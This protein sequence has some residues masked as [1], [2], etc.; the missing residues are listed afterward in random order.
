M[1]LSDI[2]LIVIIA[3]LGVGFWEAS[4]DLGE[5]T[6]LLDQ[7]IDQPLTFGGGLAIF[8]ISL[9]TWTPGIPVDTLPSWLQWVSIP[10]LF[11][12]GNFLPHFSI[13]TA[14]FAIVITAVVTLLVLYVSDLDFIWHGLLV[15]VVTFILSWYAWHCMTW[16][17]IGWG[18]NM[19]GL[20][21]EVGYQVWEN[22]VS[23]TS[24]PLMQYFF[25][26]TIPLSLYVLYQ[27]IAS[28]II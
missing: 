14:L 24:G 20:G 1:D 21:S 26:A 16:V 8:T 5:L 23:A 4:S 13:W 18:A 2:C 6:E 7:A 11:A 10:Y 12:G 3:S 25:F 9:D 17:G 28:R 22:A 27:K 15:A 19:M